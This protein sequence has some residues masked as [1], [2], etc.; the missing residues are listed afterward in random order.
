MQAAHTDLKGHPSLLICVLPNR[1][2]RSSP[3]HVQAAWIA[4]LS[5][6]KASKSLPLERTG[7]VPQPCISSSITEIFICLRVL[8]D[9]WVDTQELRSWHASSLV[10]VERFPIVL[11]CRVRIQVFRKRPAPTTS[12]RPPSPLLIVRYFD[13][14]NSKR[15]LISWKQR[16]CWD[17]RLAAT[18]L[19]D[20]LSI[21][22]RLI[23]EALTRFCVVPAT[24]R[25]VSRSRTTLQ[26]H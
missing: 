18:I 5:M 25:Y 1:K 7:E 14:R 9:Q 6:P 17:L 15:C 24:P 23:C 4:A 19:I 3:T 2:P 16:K 20:A 22:L 26:P 11:F 8:K 21:A 12:C 13:R 10:L